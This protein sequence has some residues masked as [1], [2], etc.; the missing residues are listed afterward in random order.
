MPIPRYSTILQFHYPIT[1]LAQ[2]ISDDIQIIPPC[3]TQ[4]STPRILNVASRSY[5]PTIPLS[6]YPAIW[7]RPSPIQLSTYLTVPFYNHPTVRLSNHSAILRYSYP[8]VNY[9]LYPAVPL[10]HSQYS[11]FTIPLPSYPTTDLSP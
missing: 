4:N 11:C 5:H 1:P 7:I 8:T 3:Y 6:R 10:T 2:W 9:F